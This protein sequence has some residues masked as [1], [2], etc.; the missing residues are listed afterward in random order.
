MSVNDRDRAVADAFDDWVRE[1]N[2][3][4]AWLTMQ[5]REVLSEHF[6]RHREAEAT[7]M[8]CPFCDQ[9]YCGVSGATGEA[10]DCYACDG[11]GVVTQEI[12]KGAVEAREWQAGDLMA[13]YGLAEDGQ[14]D[15]LKSLLLSE[16]AKR[17]DQLTQEPS[18]GETK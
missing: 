16:I 9:G 18:D 12:F 11:H 14:W 5:Q 1:Q 13:I 17:K 7:T 8:K 15:D 6:A 10:I 2:S 3:A 4:T